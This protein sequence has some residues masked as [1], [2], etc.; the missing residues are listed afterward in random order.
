MATVADRIIATLQA[1]GVRRV[2]GLPGDSLNGFTDAIRRSDGFSWE[3]VRHEEAAA[4]AAAADAA[5]TG[6]LA[7]CVG[8]AGPG[9][10][11]LINGLFDAQRSRVP[12][13]AIAAHISMAEIGSEYHQET[14]PQELFRE[15]SVYCEMA[16]TPESALRIL[17]IAMRT[18]VEEQGVAVVV[19]PGELFLHRSDASDAV[20]PVVP[21]RSVLRPT[22]E[23]LRR[24]ADILNAGSRVTILAGAGVAG[25]HA[26]LVELAGTLQA[27]V[28]HA[29]RGKEFVEYDNPYD[30]GMT[31]LLGFASG[32]K[33]IKEADVLLMLGTDFPYRQFYPEDA[34]VIQIDIRGR[35]LGRRTHVH[36]GL[37][38]TVADTLPALRPLLVPKADRRHLDR[39]LGHYRRTRERLDSLAVNDRNRTPIR[40]EF[41]AAQV[42][43]LAADD[44]VFTADVGSPVVWAARY[45]TMNGRRRLI[46]S[47]NHATM[48][49]A[50]PLAVGAQT[51]S[52]DRQ[53]VA[54]A[55]DGGL[56]MLFGELITLVQNRLPV[57]LV[58]FNNASLNFV[59]VEMKAAGFV[60]YGT[61]LSNPDFARVAEA[62]GLFARRVEHPADLESA[63]AAAFAHDGPALVDVITARQELTIPPTITAE[64]A[65]GFSLFAI[66]TILAGRSDELLDLITTNVARRILD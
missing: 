14:H 7:V 66:R 23:S 21:T 33:A 8:S 29:L 20:R 49:C 63:L 37:V 3:H 22:E 46:G 60:N 32:Y 57:K 48:A 59:E 38:G 36:L 51:A 27:P 65:K 13:L 1:S 42:D 64:Q 31:G 19:I 44:A 5:V 34:T 28:V 53:V 62:I 52:R 4:F 11:H 15:C 45:L 58:L 17:E 18:A 30:V 6:Q 55:G 50:L 41:V 54:L 12:V 26:Q 25:A 40:P 16:S 61:G 9:N 24:A 47:F 56:T 2:Y 10:L 35:N 39:A 43:R